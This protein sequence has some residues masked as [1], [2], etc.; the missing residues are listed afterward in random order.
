M[1]SM[2]AGIG[3]PLQRGN[4]DLFD[5]GQVHTFLKKHFL[6]WLEAL[7]L[8]GNVSDGV[9]MVRTLES[10]LTVSDSITS[11]QSYWLI[12]QAQISL[13]LAFTCNNL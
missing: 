13:K 4:S 5:N 8:M 11:L 1:F 12:Y 2:R 7:S 9:V 6:H 10:M 3:S